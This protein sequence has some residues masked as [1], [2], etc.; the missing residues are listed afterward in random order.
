[1]GSCSSIDD[2]KVGEPAKNKNNKPESASL[3]NTYPSI[4]DVIKM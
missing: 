3:I 4:E 1:M 2:N